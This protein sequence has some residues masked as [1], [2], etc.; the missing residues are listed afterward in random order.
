[1]GGLGKQ[2]WDVSW[3]EGT[4]VS[5][6]PEH[7]S[8]DVGFQSLGV[9]LVGILYHYLDVPFLSPP[10]KKSCCFLVPLKPNPKGYRAST[11]TSHEDAWHLAEGTHIAL[12]QVSALLS[13][14]DTVG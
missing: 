11:T 7:Q 3:R 10:S 9:S 5:Q 13:H 4:I 1:M 12:F 2:E 6:G 14:C 8:Q